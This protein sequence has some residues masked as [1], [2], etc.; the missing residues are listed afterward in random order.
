MLKRQT[1]LVVDDEPILADSLATVLRGNGLEARTAYNGTLGY[2]SFFRD[3]SEWVITDIEMPE[4]N[5]ID[6][7]RCIRAIN[8]S[9]KVIYT[10]GA[11]DEYW[12]LLM[13]E[14]RMFGA[15]ILRKPFSLT[16]VIEMLVDKPRLRAKVNTANISN[17][18]LSKTL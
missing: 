8:R 3:P 14:S 15:Q 9:V 11:A 13:R 1:V 10:T 16:R 6:M 18:S 17:I 12:E 4:L 2:A 7:V 5:G